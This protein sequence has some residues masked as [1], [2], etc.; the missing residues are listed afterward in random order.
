MTNQ[1]RHPRVPMSVDVKI[2][3]EGIGEKIVKTKNISDSGLFVLTEPNELPKVGEIVTG[4]VQGMIENPPILNM[5]V[6]RIE[7]EGVG[8]QFFES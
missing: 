6:V 4:S 8:L 3:H 1:R 7:P 2:Y 5:R